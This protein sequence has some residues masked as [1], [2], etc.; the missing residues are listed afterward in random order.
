MKKAIFILSFALAGCAVAQYAPARV[1]QV[2]VGR[3]E[4]EKIEL[5]RA[6]MPTRKF[7]EIGVVTVCCSTDAGKVT[8]LLQE[9]TSEKGGDALISIE[10]NADGT[11]TATAI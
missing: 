1:D 4:P 5:F 9:K 8:Q 3:T 10:I 7:E 11:G 2:Y 6:A